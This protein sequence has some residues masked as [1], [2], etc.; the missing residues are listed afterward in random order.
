MADTQE[1]PLFEEDNK[2]FETLPIQ[3]PW[4]SSSKSLGKRKAVAILGRVNMDS[5]SST[6]RPS[7]VSKMG[8]GQPSTRQARPLVD[9]LDDQPT[10]K[11][12]IDEDW[13]GRLL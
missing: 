3:N 12:S 10:E 8:S 6:A 5:G 7:N 9:I 11:D 4:A 1:M 13:R 2:D